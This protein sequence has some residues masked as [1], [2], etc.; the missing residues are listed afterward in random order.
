MTP[1][2]LI[3]IVMIF[4]GCIFTNPVN[5]EMIQ[6]GTIGTPQQDYVSIPFLKE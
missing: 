6:Y 3:S 2:L 4:V 1:I 5:S